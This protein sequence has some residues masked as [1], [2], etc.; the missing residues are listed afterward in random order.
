MSKETDKLKLSVLFSALF[1]CGNAMTTTTL[2]K[3]RI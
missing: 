2:M 3:E 1:L